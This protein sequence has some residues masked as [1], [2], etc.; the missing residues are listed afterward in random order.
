[1]LQG[2]V[3]AAYPARVVAPT[4]TQLELARSVVSSMC[5]EHSELRQVSHSLTLLQ[6]I[7][8]LHSLQLV[9]QPLSRVTNELYMS[10]TYC[11]FLSVRH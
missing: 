5:D 8:L 3:T 2:R 10:H 9:T 11:L 7:P 4:K 1:M 6:H